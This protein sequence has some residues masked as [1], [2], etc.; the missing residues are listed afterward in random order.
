M[1][2]QT[3]VFFRDRQALLQR[4]AHL[5]KQLDD[6][7]KRTVGRLELE[8][9]CSAQDELATVR[10]DKRLEVSPCDGYC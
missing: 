2:Y 1:T 7:A 6:R 4:R 5:G 8:P 3:S 9:C 10:P